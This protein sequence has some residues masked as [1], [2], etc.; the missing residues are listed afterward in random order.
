MPASL[1]A[2]QLFDFG[3]L[4]GMFG[5][6]GFFGFV[7]LL[8]QNPSIE[9]FFEFGQLVLGRRVLDRRV[10]LAFDFLLFGL[11]GAFINETIVESLFELL[12]FFIAQTLRLHQRLFLRR[13][14]FFSEENSS[15]R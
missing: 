11:V 5:D 2:F 6:F 3:G 8:T 1:A 9:E 14:G 4:V 7:F 10:H 15:V 13:S 12:K